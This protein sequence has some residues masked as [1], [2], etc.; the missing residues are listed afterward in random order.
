MFSSSMLVSASLRL[1]CGAL[2]VDLGL[3]PAESRAV[4]LLVWRA[5]GETVC[6]GD[7]WEELEHATL[8]GKFVEVA[9]LVSLAV[10][11]NNG[12]LT[13]RA[14]RRCPQ[15][16]ARG[17]P[18]PLCRNAIQQKVGVVTRWRGGGAESLLY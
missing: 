9:S 1:P 15:A 6:Y 11:R 17:W 7:V 3:Q 13:Y 8:H 4:E 10:A 16:A 5:I 18:Q 12:L 2:T 14:A